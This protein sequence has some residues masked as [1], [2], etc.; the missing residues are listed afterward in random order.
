MRAGL[1]FQPFHNTRHAA[2][3]FAIAQ[4]IDIRT[5]QELL[6]HASYATTANI[7]G[8]L[9]PEATRRATV[10]IGALLAES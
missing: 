9:Q 2:A 10:K 5:V 3:S 7:Y 1:P 4:G 6:G 8:H